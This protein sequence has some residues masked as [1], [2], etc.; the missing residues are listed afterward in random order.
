[1]RISRI[2]LETTM[3]N[4][5]FADDAPE[6]KN[7]VLKLFQ[8]IQEGKYKP[9]ASKYV[10]DELSRAGEEKRLKMMGLIDVYHVELLPVSEEVEELAAK[11]IISLRP[12]PSRW[13]GQSICWN[14]IMKSGSIPLM[15]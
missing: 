15:R 7:A 11:Y 13:Y 3:F 2:Y 1:M 14:S 9:Y 4:F 8:E 10:I 5:P 6:K 12:R